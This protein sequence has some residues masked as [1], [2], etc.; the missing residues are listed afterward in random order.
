MSNRMKTQSII[1]AEAEGGC[2]ENM[3][4]QCSSGTIEADKLWP[5]R[6]KLTTDHIRWDSLKIPPSQAF[7]E[8]ILA[9]LDEASRKLL[10][11]YLPIE[12]HIADA[13][14]CE[15]Y[16]VKLVKKDSFWFGHCLTSD[17]NRKSPGVTSYPWRR[18]LPMIL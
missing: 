8:H 15:T 10:D 18:R 3:I 5:F 2:G 13:D 11:A 6:L 17:R 9:N 7:E 12:L 1:I 16:K 4:G 14:A